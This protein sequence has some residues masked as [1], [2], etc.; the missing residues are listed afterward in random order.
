MFATN[1]FRPLPKIPA[2][3]LDS[4]E[5]V[6]EETAWP[7]LRLIYRLFLQFL[8]S[9]IDP[10]ILTY[11][12]TQQF[13]TSL[14]AILDFPDARERAEVKLVIASIFEKV[15]AHHTS[16]RT[17]TINL[18]LS[19]SDASLMAA[20]SP[21]LDLLYIFTNDIPPPMSPQMVSAFERVLLPL[22]LPS[23]CATYFD[24]LVRCT[25]MMVRKNVHLGSQ[26]IRFLQA[27]WPMTLDHK[28]QLF[29]GEV[30]QLLDESFDAVEA[31]VCD[32][33][34][35][36]ALA[37]E[38]PCTKL[39]QSALA[40]LADNN[41]QNLYNKKPEALLRIVFPA[42]YRIAEGHWKPEIQVKALT[43]MKAFLELNPDAF[44][45]VAGRFKG[46]VRAE[47]QRREQKKRAW[48]QIAECA[49][50]GDAEMGKW[51]KRGVWKTKWKEK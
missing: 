28:A 48:E 32:L 44:A 11:H 22:H 39:A 36:V 21:L 40:F 45:G 34:Q 49:A 25:L 5:A 43:V 30:R 9:R 14:F 37:A 8:E 2:V 27:H 20:A 33:L 6:I 17:L 50:K 19:V 18:L 41:F 4:D 1:V 7:H 46:D 10:R 38:S 51:G 16:L 13:F 47:G 29:I 3:L 35:Y 26:L 23:R 12:L 42:I 31:D 24:S 15:P